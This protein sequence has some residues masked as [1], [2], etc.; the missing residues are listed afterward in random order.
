MKRR[1]FLEQCGLVSSSI[2]S[3]AFLHAVTSS[4]CYANMQSE[5]KADVVIIGGGLGGCAAALAACRNG[6]RVILTEPTDWL[7][8]QLSQ[9]AVPPDEHTWIESFGRTPSY[10]QL[11]TGIRFYY[12]RNYPLTE[13]A[14]KVENLDPGNGSVSRVC[15]E[16][17][18][19]V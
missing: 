10:A 16:P 4:A 19:A 17:R 18:V 5:M 1:Q 12:K 13:A 2:F 3:P 15:H 9:Q 7:G 11:R 6:S 14:M 8:G